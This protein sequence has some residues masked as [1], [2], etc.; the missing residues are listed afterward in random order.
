MATNQSISSVLRAKYLVSFHNELEA[1]G[2][3]GPC[4][5]RSVAGPERSPVA[6]ENDRKAIQSRITQDVPALSMV[7]ENL[8][9]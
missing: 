6:T 7:R 2:T 3:A 9:E 1:S 8:S 5:F 4:R